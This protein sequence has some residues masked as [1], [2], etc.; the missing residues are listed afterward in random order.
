MFLLQPKGRQRPDTLVPR[1]ARP[2]DFMNISWK[3][4]GGHSVVFL[5][6][7]SLDSGEKK[8]LYWSSQKGS[9]GLGGQ[10]VDVNRI[11]TVKIVRLTHPEELFNFNPLAPVQLKI[12]G[13]SLIF[14]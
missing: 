10:L 4:G 7:K 9:N 14:K 3:N 12:P 5:G 11:S 8:L 2:G 13:D 6:W 1:N